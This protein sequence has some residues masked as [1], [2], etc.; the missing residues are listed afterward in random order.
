MAGKGR[1]ERSVLE[2]S[3]AK[4]EASVIRRVS[5]SPEYAA[6]WVAE[7]V[8]KLDPEVGPEDRPKPGSGWVVGL[9]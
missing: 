3:V 7:K 1:R 9:D 4:D 2:Y 8:A 5:W 6:A